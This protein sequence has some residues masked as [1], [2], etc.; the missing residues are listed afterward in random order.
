MRRPRLALAKASLLVGTL[1]LSATSFAQDFKTFKPEANR[2][3]HGATAS[4][5]WTH[6]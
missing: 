5:G 2:D 6:P 4:G 3:L 1:A